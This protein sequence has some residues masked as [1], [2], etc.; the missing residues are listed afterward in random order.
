[1]KYNGS[2]HCGAV[3]FSF[4]DADPIRGV[5]CNCSICRRRG[6]VMSEK[7][8]AATVELTQPLGVY[9]FGDRCMHHFHCTTCGI[10][11]YAE[12]IEEPSIYRVNLGCV[13]GIDALAVPIRMIDGASY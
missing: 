3:N 7:R 10:F 2:C 4:E 12:V 5:R 11:P 13:D 8:Y 1:M 6:C 9:I